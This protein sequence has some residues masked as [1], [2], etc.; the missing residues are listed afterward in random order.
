MPQTIYLPPDLRPQYIQ[1]AVSKTTDFLYDLVRMEA[2]QG[3]RKENLETQALQ[4]AEE[5]SEFAPT[6][7]GQ[8]PLFTR[9]G[10]GFSRQPL[11][12]GSV[13]M[14][15]K[16]L[17]GMIG[18][19]RGGNLQGMQNL[20]KMEEKGWKLSEGMKTND[21]EG[22]PIYEYELVSPDGLTRIP[23]KTGK[24]L[25]SSTNVNVENKI[26][27]AGEV[28]KIGEFKA[29]ID[30]MQEIQDIIDAGEGNVTGP[31]EF[32]KK[33]MD[34]WGIMPSEE[35]IKMR[36]LVARLP[37]LMYAMRGKQL[38]DKELEVA[39]NMMPRMEQDEVPFGIQLQKFNEYMMTILKGKK[40]AFKGAGYKTGG[41]PKTGTRK[42]PPLDS[43]FKKE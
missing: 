37:G 23:Y 34:N 4:R 9:K 17:P 14:G 18:L 8:T 25:S 35:R 16:E 24:R 36:S 1:R 38:S 28:G 6:S 13:M 42:R 19:Y 20:P 5:S 27:P 41:F 21:K 26:M 11:T 32:I 22:N 12:A 7:P 30:T 29:Y 33:R 2:L 31:F 43:F 10:K 3:Y 15:G 40:E 39:L